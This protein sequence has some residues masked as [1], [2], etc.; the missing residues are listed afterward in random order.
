MGPGT[1]RPRR[2]AGQPLRQ[3]AA[4]HESGHGRGVVA[5]VRLPAD[6]PADRPVRRLDRHGRAAG[7]LASRAPVDDRH[8]VRRPSRAG[9]RA[10]ADAERAGDARPRRAR[11]R[12]SSS[13][14]S[15][16]GTSL[17]ADTRG[18][19]R[20][21]CSCYAVGLVGYS[22]AR[23]VS[24]VFYALRRSRVPVDRQLCTIAR[25]P[26]RS[27]WS[28]VRVMGFRGL[29]LGTSLA[30]L[31][32]GALCSCS[33]RRQLGRHRRTAISALTFAEDRARGVGGDGSRG[34]VGVERLL[35]GAPD[36]APVH[37]L[38]RLGVTIRP[39]AC[40]LVALAARC[41]ASR[42][43]HD[44]VDGFDERCVGAQ[45]LSRVAAA[46]VIRSGAVMRMPRYPSRYSARRRSPSAP[47][48]SRT[49]LKAL[50]GANVGAVRRAD[51]FDA[52]R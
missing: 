33:L 11:R 31:V 14:C 39:S 51:S 52:G 22:A 34:R 13:C 15:S 50:I 19:G 6:V 49:A 36:P 23:I 40:W 24:P 18:H 32:N 4:R 12:R 16:A 21:R 10:D 47:A 29:A 28:L 30:A 38:A 27:A 42:S 1:H 48:R 43:S 8:G 25:Q 44:V 3:H 5:A 9:D 17:P 2:D 37:S 7:G 26:R 46:D 20:A 45:P 35:G 41:C